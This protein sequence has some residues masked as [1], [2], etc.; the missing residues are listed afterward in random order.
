ASIREEYPQLWDAAL[1]KRIHQMIEEALEVEMAFC[2]DALSQGVTGLSS[3]LMY[4][5]LQYVADQ[6]LVQ[7]GFKRRY[8]AKNPFSFMVLQD[9]QPLT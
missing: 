7:L 3:A 8:N 2:G 9:V 1:E 4:E 6:R 5:Y